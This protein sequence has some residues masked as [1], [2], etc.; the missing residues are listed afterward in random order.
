M[1]AARP[2]GGQGRDGES[3][4]DAVVAEG[5]QVRCAETAAAGYGQ[6]VLGNLDLSPQSRQV[7]GDGRDAIGFLDP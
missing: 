5:V 3:H 7:V 1:D 6:A 4:G 2:V